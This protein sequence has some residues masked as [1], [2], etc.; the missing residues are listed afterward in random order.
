MRFLCTFPE[1]HPSETS[2][3][4]LSWIISAVDSPYPNRIPVIGR[5]SQ[6]HEICNPIYF[7][8]LYIYS[9]KIKKLNK[10][11]IILMYNYV[12]MAIAKNFINF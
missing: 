7:N 10:H 4:W 9:P 8:I 2:K 5:E 1:M 11:Q 3:L 12:V 6:Y